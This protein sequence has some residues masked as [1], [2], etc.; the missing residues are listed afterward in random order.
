MVVKNSFAWMV[1]G[2]QGSGVDSGANIFARACCYGGLYVY[3]NRE[4]HS[5]IKGLH[6]YFQIRAAEHPVYC[7]R[8]YVD[9][10][11]TFDAETLVRHRREVKAKG[12]IIYD[13]SYDATGI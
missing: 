10:L 8:S 3:G 11:A 4:Y 1:G 5:N 9:L 13:P 6:S 2:A 7:H 12:G